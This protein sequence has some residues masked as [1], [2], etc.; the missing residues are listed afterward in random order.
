MSESEISVTAMA[1]DIRE[2]KSMLKIALERLEKCEE[3]QD[4]SNEKN[5][6]DHRTFYKYLYMGLGI[7]ITISTLVSL[8]S[9]FPK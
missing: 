1:L 4:K 2:M 8:F 7:T 5:E 3:N 6:N 9:R